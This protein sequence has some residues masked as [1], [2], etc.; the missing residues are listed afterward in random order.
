MQDYEPMDEISVFY[1]SKSVADSISV[2]ENKKKLQ[3]DDL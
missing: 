2:T 1:N 3:D